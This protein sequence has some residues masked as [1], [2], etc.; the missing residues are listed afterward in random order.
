MIKKMIKGINNDAAL[1]LKRQL[2]HLLLGLIIIF[3]LRLK[4]IDWK[5]LL[6][7]LIIGFVISV[8]HFFKRIALLRFFMDHFD[9]KS[10]FLPGWGALTFFFGILLTVFLFSE[11]AAIIGII[12]LVFG[13][14]FSTLIGF[15]FG[16]NKLPWNKSKTF[17]GLIS[18]FLASIIGILLLS[19]MAFSKELFLMSVIV[20]LLGSIIESLSA[21]KHNY[22]TDDNILIPMFSALL[23]ELLLIIL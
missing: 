19:G 20:S 22:F 18:G 23:A 5:I 15:Y 4:I 17:E 10:E 2:F 21:K 11:L 16:S 14:C 12:V 3:L 6:L 13:D 9:R 1:E 8:T 7:I